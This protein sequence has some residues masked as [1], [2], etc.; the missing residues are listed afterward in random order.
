MV[1]LDLLTMHKYFIMK[2]NPYIS[3]AEAQS[4]H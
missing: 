2:P 3:D 1:L 4:A